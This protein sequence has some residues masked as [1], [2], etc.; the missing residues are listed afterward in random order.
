MNPGHESPTPAEIVVFDPLSRKIALPMSA[1]RQTAALSR[2]GTLSLCLL[3]L[4][5]KCRQRSHC[6]QVHA[7][8]AIV[9]RLRES[10]LAMP[11]CCLAHGD[12]A[13]GRFDPEW[14]HARVRIGPCTIAATSLAFTA[15]LKAVFPPSQPIQ[16]LVSIPLHQIC[17]VH[18][19]NSCR[20]GE[21]CRYVH[22]CR[23]VIDSQL[24]NALPGLVT[25]L[26]ARHAERQRRSQ[27]SLPPHNNAS[28]GA[29]PGDSPQ[30]AL[31]QTPQQGP[32]ATHAPT[33][34]STMLGDSHHGAA[35]PSPLAVL[36]NYSSVS[37]LQP[38]AAMPPP[39]QAAHGS[40]TPA[41]VF[42]AAPSAAAPPMWVPTPAPPQVFVVMPDNTLRPLAG[43]PN[44]GQPSA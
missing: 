6:R 33:V 32:T 29:A 17:R 31:A 24:Q 3:H 12:V 10:A 41:P 18:G 43:L 14:K 13:A 25:P 7:D 8:R 23:D 2:E 19:R 20:Y 42:V 21:E 26:E 1:V 40:V 37:Y 5:G 39:S 38:H 36:P 30:Q 4:D 9:L 44:T 35:Y 11:T 22:V 27:A 15:A 16:P 34:G 28:P